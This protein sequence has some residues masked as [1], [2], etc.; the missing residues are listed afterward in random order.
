MF[1]YNYDDLFEQCMRMLGYSYCVRTTATDLSTRA[2]VEVNHVHG[3]LPQHWNCDEILAPLIL[4]NK[5]YRAERAAIDKGW[6]AAIVNSLHSKVGLFL[7]L[8]G[9]DE[10]ILDVLKRAQDMIERGTEYHGYW[11]MTPDAYKRNAQEIIDVKMCP[12]PLEVDDFPRFVFRVCQEADKPNNSRQPLICCS[13]SRQGKSLEKS[14]VRRHGPL[15]QGTT[16]VSVPPFL[17]FGVQ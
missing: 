5:S 6:S 13:I 3:Y 17:P 9:D 12:I 14:G 8:S 7:G 11:L 10:G 4:S 16:E 1:T 15:H 2:D